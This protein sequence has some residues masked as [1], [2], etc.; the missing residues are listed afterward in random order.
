MTKMDIYRQ[1]TGQYVPIKNEFADGTP[2]DRLFE[3]ATLA[4][5]R[6]CRRA[7]FELDDPD[8]MELIESLEKI[9]EI[10]ALKMYSYAL[11]WGDLPEEE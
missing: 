7:G 3:Q 11:V 4:R 2:C 6:I 8:I 10:F 1:M 5:E 9:R